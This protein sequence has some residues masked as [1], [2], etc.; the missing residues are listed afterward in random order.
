MSPF[1]P[2]P[3]LVILKSGHSEREVDGPA[4][5]FAQVASSAGLGL[6]F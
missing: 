2:L 6:I 5:F 3:S 1:D 4:R